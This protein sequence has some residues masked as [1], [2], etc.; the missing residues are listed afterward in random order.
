MIS[1]I[2][3]INGK[4][5]TLYLAPKDYHQYI[6]VDGKL[7]SII[8]TESFS[9]LMKGAMKIFQIFRNTRLLCLFQT[10]LG[11]IA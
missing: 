3:F 9:R 7:I 6:Q 5:V 10:E 8:Y 4:F 11:P 2:T 1:F